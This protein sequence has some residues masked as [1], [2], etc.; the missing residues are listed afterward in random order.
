MPNPNPNMSGITQRIKQKKVLKLRRLV[1][2]RPK[3]KDE[4]YMDEAKIEDYADSLAD[5][6]TDDPKVLNSLLK[7]LEIKKRYESKAVA[8]DDTDQLLKDVLDDS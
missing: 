4:K 3:W 2:K 8:S 6:V 1:R 5:N 7:W